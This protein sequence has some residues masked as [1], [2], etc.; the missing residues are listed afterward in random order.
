MV[1]QESGW[2]SEGHSLMKSDGRV[3]RTT[4]ENSL[5]VQVVGNHELTSTPHDPTGT[6]MCQERDVREEVHVRKKKSNEE[7]R[8][9]GISW[10]RKCVALRQPANPPL[11]PTVMS[12]SCQRQTASVVQAKTST[13]GLCEETQVHCTAALPF[14]FIVCLSR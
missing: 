2:D 10:K 13:R 5:K 1:L 14:S 7:M 9:R 3:V 4:R 11:E 8:T 12:T 6:V